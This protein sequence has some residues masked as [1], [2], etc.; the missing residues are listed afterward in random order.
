M[1]LLDSRRLT[2]INVVSDVPGTVVGPGHAVEPDR[3]VVANREHGGAAYVAR[4][5][6]RETN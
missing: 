1:E 6:H 2:G 4:G 5:E 3:P